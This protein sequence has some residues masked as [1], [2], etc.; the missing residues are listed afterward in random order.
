MGKLRFFGRALKRS[1]FGSLVMAGKFDGCGG[2]R[3]DRR[4]NGGMAS[5]HGVVK[6]TSLIYE[7]G[8]CVRW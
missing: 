5:L 6:S 8:N 4:V 2:E 3:E 7:S 1:R